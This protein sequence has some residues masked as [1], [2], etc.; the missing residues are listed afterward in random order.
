MRRYASQR[1]TA[2]AIPITVFSLGIPDSANP[3]AVGGLSDDHGSKGTKLR[4]RHSRLMVE[5]AVQ[6]LIVVM[7]VEDE[8]MIR[9]VLA[10]SLSDTGFDVIEAVHAQDAIRILHAEAQRVHALFTDVHMPGE[11]NGVGLAHHTRSNWPWISL[12]LTSGR[13]CPTAEEMPTG[14]RFIPKPYDLSDVAR[15]IRE[16]VQ[17]D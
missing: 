4:H 14:T 16:L 6:N 15:H 12:L 11:M 13:A 8:A 3:T 5:P 7:I 1:A 17:A 9:L 10:E 2:A